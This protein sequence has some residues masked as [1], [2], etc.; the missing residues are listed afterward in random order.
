MGSLGQRARARLGEVVAGFELERIESEDVLSVRMTG[1]SMTS[2]VSLCILHSR[3]SMLPGFRSGFARAAWLSQTVDHGII[4]SVL[5]SGLTDDQVP[6]VALEHIGGETLETYLERRAGT[7]PPAEALRIVRELADGLAAIAA[8]SCVHGA[9]QP[10]S[11]ALTE[12]G[13]V[14]LLNTGWTH[15]REL[16]AGHLGHSSIPGLA[17][18]LSPNQA[19]GNPP[20]QE[21]DVWSLAAILYELLAGVRLR[22]GTSDSDVLEQAASLEA[23]SLH[24]ATPDAPRELAE[25]LERAFHPEPMRRL[26]AAELAVQ[27]QLL[28]QQTQIATLRRLPRREPEYDARTG[29]RLHDTSPAAPPSHSGVSPLNLPPEYATGTL[30]PMPSR[31]LPGSAGT[32]SS[33]GAQQQ[34]DTLHPKKR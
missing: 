26:K 7:V 13:A 4:P 19:R 6:F 28:A 18:Y 9:I 11:I 3:W 16:A 20:T 22:S 31:S 2:S 34:I 21:D 5:E 1:R 8:Q 15:L 32:Y 12:S 17:G 10:H 24:D 23:P 33:R 25:L 27:C 29:A 30:S 14:R